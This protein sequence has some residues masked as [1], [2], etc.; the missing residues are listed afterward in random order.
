MDYQVTCAAARSH[1]IEESGDRSWKAIGGIVLGSYDRCRQYRGAWRSIKLIP[2]S[3][4]FEYLDWVVVTGRYRTFAASKRAALY[5]R[6]DNLLHLL[7]PALPKTD[8][9]ATE[10][11]AFVVT[12]EDDQRFDLI[13]RTILVSTCIQAAGASVSLLRLV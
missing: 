10:N 5:Q 13:S 4:D 9:G 2:P 12:L 11:L 7:T 8:R 6:S 3:L 1:P